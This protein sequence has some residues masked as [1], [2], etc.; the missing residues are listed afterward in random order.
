MRSP[1]GLGHGQT[2]PS[3]VFDC[4]TRPRLPTFSVIGSRGWM[5]SCRAG[6]EPSDPPCFHG[7]YSTAAPPAGCGVK[8][9]C[10]WDRLW[11]R[12]GT[13]PDDPGTSTDRGH[14]R[15]RTPR[16]PA[17]EARF[18][19]LER[20]V[21]EWAEE[22]SN[23]RPT[24]YELAHLQ[25]FCAQLALVSAAAFGWPGSDLPSWGHGLGHGSGS[26]TRC[27]GQLRVRAVSESRRGR[28]R[29]PR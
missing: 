15:A 12:H 29:M 7:S 6:W 3:T 13:E 4:S 1:L 25:G 17:C 19:G 8:L 24:D 22:D 28:R 20:G 26:E 18:H 23:L 11:D 21:S 2:P 14:G 27:D 5:R 10:P 9:S 16:D